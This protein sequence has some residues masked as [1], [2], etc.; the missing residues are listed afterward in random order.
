MP[1]LG[2]GHVT[3]RRKCFAEDTKRRLGWT[4]VS[5]RYN[6]SLAEG[7]VAFYQLGEYESDGNSGSKVCRVQPVS[8]L[9]DCCEVSG[10]EKI[11]E[12]PS[13]PMDHCPPGTRPTQRPLEHSV[14]IVKCHSRNA[15]TAGIPRGSRLSLPCH[16]SSWQPTDGVER[17]KTRSSRTVRSS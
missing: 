17:T 15:H 16:D 10:P 11:G 1:R 7:A 14:Q 12:N 13:Y 4:Y 9:H 5:A 6:Y 2:I 8:I 3:R